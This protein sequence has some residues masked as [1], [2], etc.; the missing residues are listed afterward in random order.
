MSYGGVYFWGLE[1]IFVL[2]C[3]SLPSDTYCIFCV[4]LQCSRLPCTTFV[5]LSLTPFPKYLIF[6]CTLGPIS[7]STV[8]MRLLNCTSMCRVWCRLVWALALWLFIVSYGNCTHDQLQ[9]TSSNVHTCFLKLAMTNIVQWHFDFSTWNRAREGNS[10]LYDS[11]A[12]L[13]SPCCFQAGIV[14]YIAETTY[15]IIVNSCCQGLTPFH[16]G[17]HSLVLSMT[18]VDFLMVL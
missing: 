4:L 17:R 16:G 14:C 11:P 15:Y 2:H 18:I 6:G 10:V 3:T 9:Q 12:A 8:G 7:I 1:L 13:C 5:A